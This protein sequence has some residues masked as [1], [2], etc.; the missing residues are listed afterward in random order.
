MQ[1]ELSEGST[2]PTKPPLSCCLLVWV[3]L[4]HL[5]QEVAESKIS[6]LGGCDQSVFKVSN[7]FIRQAAQNIL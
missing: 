5:W 4:L 7:C 3:K 6:E 2:S 1:L